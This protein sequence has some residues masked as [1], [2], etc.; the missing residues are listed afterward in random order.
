M[1]FNDLFVPDEDEL[2]EHYPN[3]LERMADKVVHAVGLIGAAIGGG[4]LFAMAL[5]K[6]GVPLMAGVALYAVCLLAML[7]CSAVYNLARPSPARRVLRRID[8]AA[9]FL[10]IAGSITPFALKLLA[11]GASATAITFLWSCA[12]AGGICKVCF[13]RI[14]DRTW[15]IIYVAFGWLATLSIAPAIQGL[16]MTVIALLASGGLIYSAGVLIYLNHAAPFRR[17]IWHGLVLLAAS[18]HFSAVAIGLI[19][20]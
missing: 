17:A 20:S 12:F 6:G 2:V 19:L 8:E 15:C 14:S 4:V 9:I 5:S 1:A 7:A 16:P 13:P 10:M 3:A 18:V 11:P